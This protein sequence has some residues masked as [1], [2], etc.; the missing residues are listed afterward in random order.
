LILTFAWS[1]SRSDASVMTHVNAGFCGVGV[2]LDPPGPSWLFWSFTQWK[3]SASIFNTSSGSWPATLSITGRCVSPRNH[4][5]SH[6]HTS[7]DSLSDPPV[8]TTPSGVTVSAI[9]LLVNTSLPP[10]VAAMTIP[11]LPHNPS[12][13]SSPSS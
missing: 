5:R 1:I 10:P 11:F 3:K 7:G 8:H 13:A 9:T 12:V 6:V 4:G 2:R